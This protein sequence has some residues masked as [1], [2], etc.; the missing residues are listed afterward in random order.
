[1]RIAIALLRLKVKQ[2]FQENA[3][4]HFPPAPAKI[5]Y[6]FGLHSWVSLIAFH[7]CNSTVFVL[8]LHLLYF[9]PRPSVI[10]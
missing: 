4:L 8:R 5:F 2:K 7:I 9:T 10:H 1:M 3:V 6:I